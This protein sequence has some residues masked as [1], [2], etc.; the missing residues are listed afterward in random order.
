[1]CGDEAAVD[2]VLVS[3]VVVELK[4]RVKGCSICKGSADLMADR[5][6]NRTPDELRTAIPVLGELPELAGV[7]AFPARLA[8][9]ELPWR[10]LAEAL[11]RA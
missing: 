1:L 4:H 10:A 9:A 2:L 3:G 6:I 11:K 8:C 7:R 5:A